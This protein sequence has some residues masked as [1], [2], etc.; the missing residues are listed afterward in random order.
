MLI[1]CLPSVLV[2]LSAFPSFCIFMYRLSPVTHFVAALLPATIGDASATRSPN[3]VL[4]LNPPSGSTCGSY[5]AAF[6]QQSGGQVLNPQA[7]SGCQYCIVTHTT[8]V[9]Q[10][11]DIA[12]EERW[13]QWG[14]TLAY[15]VFNV[16]VAVALYW[17]FRV[18]RVKRERR[19][20]DATAIREK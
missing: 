10:R 20:A 12:F 2:V 17:A 1:S 6:I 18:P 16:G 4:T 11:F 3:E 15:S 19:P 13:W 8:A 5:L 7:M 14:V 9:L